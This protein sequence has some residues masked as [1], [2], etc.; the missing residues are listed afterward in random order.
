[1]SSILSQMP[2]DFKKKEEK[3][4]AVKQLS[5]IVAVLPIRN[6][7][8][9]LNQP[10]KYFDDAA[11]EE[12]TQSI[13]VHGLIQ[14]ITVRRLGHE[15]FQLISGE[16]R[17]RASKN[18]GLKEIPAY[19]RL[20]NDQEMLEMALVE[21][22]QR[23][24]LNPIEIA[25]TYRRLKDECSFTDEQLAGRVGKNRTSITNYLRL[26]TLPPEL[27][28]S[29]KEGSM[30][31]GHAKMLAGKDLALQ[32][33]L[34]SQI[35]EKG[36]SV[37]DVEEYIRKYK[38]GRN[39]TMT[40]TQLPPVYKKVQDDLGRRFDTRVSLKRKKGGKGQIV[41]NFSNDEDLNRILDLIQDDG[42]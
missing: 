34:H 42:F 26:L 38:E 8:T 12:L 14:P 32:L 19:I 3:A 5:N 13:K 39:K 15:K 25:I 40:K 1:M 21:N 16:R 33:S 27:Q 11:L 17:L 41:I 24:N 22:I 28:E 20:A 37:R 4:K 18:A 31:M 9:Y 35:L 6:I 2:V 10:R 36:L 30:S 7:E 23:E 29:L